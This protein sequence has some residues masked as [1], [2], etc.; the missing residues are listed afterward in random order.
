MTGISVFPVIM[1]LIAEIK[2]PSEEDFVFLVY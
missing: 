2:K 1:S